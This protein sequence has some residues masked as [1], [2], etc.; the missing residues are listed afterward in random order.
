MV[1]L[2]RWYA[3]G[4]PQPCIH[5]QSIYMGR[6]IQFPSSLSSNHPFSRCAN[7][8][9][10]KISECLRSD[11]RSCPTKPAYVFR[12]QRRARGFP[13]TPLVPR[14]PAPWETHQ[15]REKRLPMPLLL[16][17]L[18]MSVCGRAGPL[19]ESAP[20]LSRRKDQTRPDRT[21]HP[22]DPL[23]KPYCVC[24]NSRKEA[25]GG[26]NAACAPLSQS[27][28]VCQEGCG[29]KSYWAFR[30]PTPPVVQ[31]LLSRVVFVITFLSRHPSAYR[32]GI[33][34]ES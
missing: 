2:V 4:V 23:S 26:Y 18:E 6:I 11:C 21:P 13:P 30:C 24:I 16:E 34:S 19:I 32:A 8:K 15:N 14:R 20:S 9:N 7:Q 3:Y 25:Q 29:E 10:P 27:K 12:K 5:L 31:S 28:P 22:C 33:C 1:L 17:E